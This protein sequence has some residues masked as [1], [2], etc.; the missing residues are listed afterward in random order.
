MGTEHLFPNFPDWSNKCVKREGQGFKK[1]PGWKEEEQGPRN[2]NDGFDL[3][4][5]NDS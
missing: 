1:R 5:N 3:G 2:S 4:P